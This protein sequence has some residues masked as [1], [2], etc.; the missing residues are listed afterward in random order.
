MKNESFGLSPFKMR[1]AGGGGFTVVYRMDFG[2]LLQYVKIKGTEIT[3]IH[4]TAISKEL[5]KALKVEAKA[6]F[7]K[8]AAIIGP[9]D[10][11]M[12]P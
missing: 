4:S 9:E 1:R 10:K 3:E 6:N 7:K 11:G 2:Y 8:M 5:F 12:T